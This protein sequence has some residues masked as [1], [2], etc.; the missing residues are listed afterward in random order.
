MQ[1]LVLGLLELFLVLCAFNHQPRFLIGELG[2]LLLDDDVEE[3]V[4]KANTCDHEI[5]DCDLDCNLRKVVRIAELRSEVKL[6]SLGILKCLVAKLDHHTIPLLVRL[7][8]QDRLNGWVRLLQD[9]LDEERG[10]IAEATLQVPEVVTV[11]E[12]DNLALLWRLHLLDPLVGLPL[13]VDAQRPP[14]SLVHDDAILDGE[15]VVGKAPNRPVSDLHWLTEALHQRE[16]RGARDALLLRNRRPTCHCPLAEVGRECSEVGDQAAGDDRVAGEADVVVA[17]IYG[18]LRP[19]GLLTPQ[20]LDERL[21]ACDLLLAQV[22]LVGQVVLLRVEGVQLRL[23]L[24][25]LVEHLPQRGALIV[26]RR[27]HDGQLCLR[28][29]QGLLLRADHLR[30]AVVDLHGADPHADAEGRGAAGLHPLGLEV[31]ERGEGSD[32]LDR[33]RWDVILVEGGQGLQESVLADHLQG[34][35]PVVLHH[36]PALVLHACR[37]DVLEQA[38]RLQHK[39]HW[40]WRVFHRL[41]LPD[42]L[43]GER[44]K[45]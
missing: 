29:R 7:L 35:L 39:L 9:V 12:L 21:G 42:I 20:G 30:G 43:G 1:D 31:V 11:G 4:L 36:L 32:P 37:L 3:L 22:H 41:D 5:E 16:G 44:V 33:R 45:G 25:K 8:E 13:R 28:R 24:R 40:R 26:Q 18:V 23:E 17:E 14:A 6:E 38:H 34:G 19:P 2:P 15:R 27:H 10:A